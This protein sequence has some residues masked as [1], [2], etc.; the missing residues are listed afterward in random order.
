LSDVAELPEL[1][2]APWDDPRLCGVI[3]FPHLQIPPGTRRGVVP[4][5]AAAALIESLQTIEA[6]IVAG[7]DERARADAASLS[8]DM[9][10][11]LA[12]LFTKVTGFVPHLEWFPVARRGGAVEGASPNG[13]AV[14]P[15]RSTEPEPEPPGGEPRQSEIFPPGPLH[16]VAVRPPKIDLASDE[17]RILRAEARDE[18]GHVI[19]EGVNFEWSAD[20]ALALVPDGARATLTAVASEGE[21]SVTVVARQLDRERT[22]AVPVRIV[23]A[24]ARRS[25]AGIPQ[26]EE[27]NEPLQPWRSR[28]LEDG[29]QINVGHPDYRALSTEARPRLR[30]LAMLLSKEV[31]SRN[32][33]QPGLGTILEELV[34]LLAA[35]ERSGAWGRT[36]DGG[37]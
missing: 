15:A 2:H 19:R 24:R 17:S 35:L 5:A 10:K 8:D 11:Q 6:K 4:D 18:H 20:V 26:P 32:F 22:C 7:L 31:V 25:D 14:S 33:P 37:G 16:L 13:S 30:Y 36:R 21:A 34:G 27:V 9:H 28:L 23:A 12:R 3:D 1:A 29:W